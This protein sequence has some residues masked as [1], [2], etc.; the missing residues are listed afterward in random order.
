M[1]TNSKI[2][3]IRNLTTGAGVGS[4]TV[5][6]RHSLDSF[7]STV[8]TAT[9]LAG[10]TGCYEFTNVSSRY[11]LKLFVNGVVDTSF[12]GTNG[13]TSFAPD[14]TI[15]VN[16]D[17]HFDVK[18]QKLVNVG[19]AT[20]DTDGLNRR[21]GDARFLRLAGGTMAGAIDMDGRKITGL[22]DA[23][24]D[25]DAMNKR[26]TEQMLVDNDYAKRTDSNLFTEPNVFSDAVSFSTICPIT[27]VPPST[28]LCLT[29]KQY[30]D[31]AID[32]L[33]V[34]PFQES[35]NVIRLI[36][37]GIQE[38]NK[39]YTT[40]ASGQNACRQ[41][42]SSNRRMTLEIRGCGETNGTAI[43]FDNGGISGNSTFNDYVSVNGINQNVIA[44]IP[45]ES[46]SVS[47]GGVVISNITLKSDDDGATPS[48]TNFIFNNVFFD[49]TVGTIGFTACE[50]RNCIIKVN[51]GT[52]TFTNCKGANVSTNVDLPDTI[53]GF[54]GL[55]VD[56]L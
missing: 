13:A 16:D 52:P 3:V 26:T 7:G 36:V 53:S 19:D 32:E 49:L 47:A 27:D 51:D 40:Y 34:T 4:L 20:A 38:T 8:Y 15:L 56:D 11:L 35:G 30:V 46:W 21:S 28:P 22:A 54:G 14:E 6:I 39:V 25:T 50:F 5:T 33:I 18:S 43:Q 17:G 1:A 41:Y 31:D 10:K 24:T 23:T 44:S 55:N 9:P 29:N 42:A 2:V 12:G 45:D 48:F 37:G